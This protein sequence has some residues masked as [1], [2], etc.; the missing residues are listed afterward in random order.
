MSITGKA[1][2]LVIDVQ[3]GMID[4]TSKFYD[5]AVVEQVMKIKDLI[6]ACKKK[7]IPCIF[8]QEKH[9]AN[10]IDFGR[11][12]DGSE[13]VH[14]L[15]TSPRIRVPEEIGYV[16]GE[17]IL[18][19]KRRYSSFWGTDLVSVLNGCDVHPGDTLILC[20][21]LTDVCVHYT[22]VDAHQSDYR[23]KVVEDL[24]GGSSPHFHE[25]AMAAMKYLQSDAPVTLEEILKDIEAYEA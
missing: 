25:G 17:D 2:L 12:L 9:R 3:Y 14:A 15:E 23:F 8:M 5:P 24:C 7:D 6:D 16:D 21:Y 19:P 10:H 13:G 4:P 22:A 11:E 20:G 1:A 18:I